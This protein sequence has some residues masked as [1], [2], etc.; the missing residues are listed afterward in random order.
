MG[1]HDHPHSPLSLRTSPPCGALLAVQMGPL[2]MEKL[3]AH[4]NSILDSQGHCVVCVAEGVGQEGAEHGIDPQGYAIL[5]VGPRH[6]FG[7]RQGCL[8]IAALC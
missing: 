4:V 6:R 7:R 1:R 8:L 2:K 3:L 5:K